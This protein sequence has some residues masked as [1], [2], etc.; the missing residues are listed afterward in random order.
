LKFLNVGAIIEIF[1]KKNENLDQFLG[2]I[3]DQF[4][5]QFMGQILDQFLGQILDQFLDQILDQFLD[6]F[7]TNFWDKFWA[8]NLKKQ[9]YKRCHTIYQFQ[10]S[11]KDKKIIHFLQF[12]EFSNYI[13]RSDIV[14]N[15]MHILFNPQ[16]FPA[17][18]QRK[19]ESIFIVLPILK[20]YEKYLQELLM[21]PGRVSAKF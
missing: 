3:L 10:N 12:L 15:I 13:N 17:A 8:R 14:E 1:I 19:M 9:Y 21:D 2:Q 11:E 18:I 4:L 16:N 5:D 6:Q 20:H 7:W